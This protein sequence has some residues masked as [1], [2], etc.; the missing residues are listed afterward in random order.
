MKSTKGFTL[1]ELLA[2]IV[3]LAIIALIVTPFVTE[4]IQNAR[5]GADKNATY[6]IINAAELYYATQLA[7]DSAESGA[8]TFKA[9]TFTFTNSNSNSVEPAANGESANFE[10]KGK[11]P[12]A[13]TL[14][15]DGDGVITLTGVKFSD[16]GKTYA[17]SVGNEVVGS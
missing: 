1:L 3:V 16:S 2:V 8:G 12:Q 4:A 6:G 17:Y 14:S 11:A 5:D 7:T 10:F 15:I 13:G 9:T